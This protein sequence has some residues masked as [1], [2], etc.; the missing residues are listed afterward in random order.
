MG[1][2]QAG[3]ECERIRQERID[4]QNVDY[5]PMLLDEVAGGAHTLSGYRIVPSEVERLTQPEYETQIGIDQ[6]NRCRC[7][8]SGPDG[9]SLGLS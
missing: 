5:E 7:F 4:H 8:L 2:S 6:E 9:S 3:N 1:L